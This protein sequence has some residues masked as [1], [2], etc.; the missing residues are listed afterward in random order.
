M[1][2]REIGSLRLCADLEVQLKSKV[3]DEVYPTPAIENIFHKIHGTSDFGNID[4]SD[5]HYQTEFD[6][7]ENKNAQSPHLKERS[8]CAGFLGA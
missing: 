7:D 5:A 4:I 6:K 8:G 2:A 1:R 3:M